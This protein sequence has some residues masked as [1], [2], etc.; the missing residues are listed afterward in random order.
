MNPNKKVLITVLSFVLAMVVIACSCGTIIPIIPTPTTA[1]PPNPMPGLAGTWHNPGTN[2]V[3]EIAWQ[4]NQ[5]VV[6]SCTWQGSS[7]LITSQSW[8]GSSLIWSYYDSDMSLTVTLTTTSLSGDNL[9]VDWSLSDGSSGSTSLLRGDVTVEPGI[10]TNPDSLTVT[11]AEAGVV[12]NDTG[13]SIAIPAG[14]VPANDDGSVGSMIFSITEDL[15]TVPSLPGGFAQVGPVVNLGPEGFVF[16]QPVTISLPIPAD[17][18]PSTVVGGAY[19]NAGQGTWNLVPGSVDE[20]SYTVQVSTT[21]LSTWTAYGFPV[22][23]SITGMDPGYPP[24]DVTN[25]GYFD[26]ARPTG[27]TGYGGPNATYNGATSWHGVCV[28]S[29]VYDDPSVANWWLPPQDYTMK[30]DNY[31]GGYGS[32]NWSSSGRYWLPNGRYQVVELIGQSEIN[33]GD[34]LYIP[35]TYDMWR[36]LGTITLTGGQTVEF[37][38]PSVPYGAEGWTVGRPPCWGERTT[39]V[40]VGDLQ[41]TLNWSSNADIDL[42]VIE[43][44]GEEIWYQNTVSSMGGELD[45]DNQCADF[46]LGRPENIYWTLPPYGWYQVNVVYYEDCGGAGPVNFTIRVCIQGNCSN[47]IGGTVNAVDE[48]VSVTSFEYP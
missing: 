39:S 35:Q 31:W 10:L 15:T 44:G 28:T 16:E 38:Y 41:V 14:A 6:L 46:S 26:I 32:P 25:G 3:Y 20:T 7:Y 34:P 12:T 5:Y 27:S 37:P 19:F 40:G 9:Y 17:V 30:V 13:V 29:V 42:H 36:N 2:D 18:D 48:T 47:P 22:G 1:P 24:A 43:P 45:R 23:G 8:T 33:P 4:N 11:S 21:H